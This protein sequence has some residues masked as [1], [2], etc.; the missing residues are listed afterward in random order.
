MLSNLHGSSCCSSHTH[1]SGSHGDVVAFPHLQVDIDRSESMECHI[2][3]AHCRS[4]SSG[5]TRDD[6]ID[7]VWHTDA[8]TQV[9][10]ETKK[11][12]TRWVIGDVGCRWHSLVANNS[13]NRFFPFKDALYDAAIQAK[14]TF[15]RNDSAKNCVIVQE[16]NDS[17]TR[18]D[19]SRLQEDRATNACR[20][21]FKFECDCLLG[22][23]KGTNRNRKILVCLP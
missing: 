15:A 5:H 4:S 18:S 16:Q 1:F 19:S 3:S 22:I 23:I 9:W 20:K 8:N 13:T 12:T 11:F 14:P 6:F 2:D 7:K 21:S 10:I 17:V